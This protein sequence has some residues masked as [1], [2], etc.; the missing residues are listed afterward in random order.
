MPQNNSNDEYSQM[1]KEYKFARKFWAPA[2]VTSW[3]AVKILIAAF[4]CLVLF[5]LIY[6]AF[7]ASLLTGVIGIFVFAGCLFIG[8]ADLRHAVVNRLFRRS[9]EQVQVV[10]SFN[11][12]TYYFLKG[13]DDILFL[14]NGRH[15]TAIGLF[16][17]KAIPLI[18]KG[19]F[20]RFIRSLYQ[21]Q[22]PV[23]WNYVQTPIDQGA[24]L[25][26]QYSETVSQEERDYQRDHPQAFDEQVENNNGVWGARLLL[27]TRCSVL[28]LFNVEANRLTL[29]QQMKADL[30]KISTAFTSAYPHT[31]LEL[32]HGKELEKAFSVSL[33]GGG[34]PAF[35]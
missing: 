1:E 26:S 13:H 24:L 16:K 15:L 6:L 4:G 28:T 3:R 20:E 29:Y 23:Y 30:F 35:F 9:F 12:L 5:Y 18:I 25:D 21:Q 17:L 27:G 10:Q 31:V 8:S 19:N 7:T 22:V 14:E 11:N 2:T 32:L 34:I 33:T